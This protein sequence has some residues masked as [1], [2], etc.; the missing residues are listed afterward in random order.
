MITSI[1]ALLACML[2]TGCHR[3]T[4]NDDAPISSADWDATMT[5]LP[6]C[7]AASS[8]FE[9]S[10]ALRAWRLRAPHGTL[11]LPNTFREAS[12]PR[13][14]VRQWTASD[15]SVVEIETARAP[16]GGLA[17]DND[18]R[19]IIEND[20][21]LPLKGHFAQ[22]MQ[23]RF[24]DVRSDRIMFAA[25]ASTVVRTNE[26]VNVRITAPTARGRMRLLSALSFMV[27]E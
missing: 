14:G 22:V 10:E 13:K 27:L 20:C 1:A 11:A 19:L 16:S 21:A 25:A 18:S 3:G 26:A 6:R 8:T 12:A 9:V 2:L 17:S 4:S 24:T 23:F 15:L 5:R 7:L